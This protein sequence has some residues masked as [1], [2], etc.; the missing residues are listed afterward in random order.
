M[1]PMTPVHVPLYETYREYAIAEVTGSEEPVR[2]ATGSRAG[3]GFAV[4][5]LGAG[6]SG[7]KWVVRANEGPRYLA[8]NGDEGEPVHGIAITLNVLRICFSKAC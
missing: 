2:M 1:L 5:G 4:C 6:P 3:N 7:K 8:V